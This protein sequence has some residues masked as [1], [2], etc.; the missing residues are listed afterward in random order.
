MP[1]HR[2]GHRERAGGAPPRKAAPEY[3]ARTSGLAVARALPS[4]PAQGVCGLPGVGEQVMGD[5]GVSS[6]FQEPAG[7]DP[8][9]ASCWPSTRTISVTASLTSRSSM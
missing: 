5:V 4:S 9:S 3:Q 7:T 8:S 1:G 2:V 6:S